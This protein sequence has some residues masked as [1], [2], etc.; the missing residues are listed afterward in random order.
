MVVS[1]LEEHEKFIKSLIEDRSQEAMVG[2]YLSLLF[3]V[4][5][6]IL[7]IYVYVFM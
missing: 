3:G 7:V 6:I 1:F 5:T 4:L 2:Y